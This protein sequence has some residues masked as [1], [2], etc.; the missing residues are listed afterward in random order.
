ME[1]K[2]CLITGASDGIGKAA[3]QELARKGFKILIHGRNKAK[4]EAAC[5]EITTATGNRNIDVL[6][7]DFTSLKDIRN[8]A[9][10]VK[11]KYDQLD[12]LINNAGG[13]LNEKRATSPEGYEKT[14]VLNHLAP[15]LLTGLLFDELRKS[16]EARII[17]TSSMAYRMAQPDFNDF[18]MEKRYS[19]MLAYGN[20]KLY[21]ILF[22]LEMARKL[23]A[24]HIEHLFV[25]ALHPGVVRTNFSLD[26]D[27]R[28]K[29]FFRLF[30]PFLIS[31]EQGAD[32][33]LYL[34]TNQEA[35]KYNGQFLKKRKPVPFI[36][37]FGKP[38]YTSR[39]WE[40]SENLT[41]IHFLQN[42]HSLK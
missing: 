2:I 1:N 39:I 26:T 17:N 11:K 4:T 9:E 12:I 37:K 14:L 15:F 36:K 18:Q 27:S 13:V 24:F 22:T 29:F 10:E 20:A 34:A 23:K 6:L 40:I 5:K 8:L 3:A 7:A 42:S 21:S 31:P 35:R 30:K 38:E 41:G 16:S 32:T 19:S 33:I 25:N 28:M